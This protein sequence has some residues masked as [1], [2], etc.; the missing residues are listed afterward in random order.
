[1]RALTAVL[2]TGCN[3]DCAYCFQNAR[4]PRRSLSWPTLRAALD[5]LLASERD[6]VELAF[7]G[8]EPLLEFP[9]IEQAFAYVARRRRADQTVRYRLYTNGMLMGGR[10]AAFLATHQVKTQL[11]LDGVPSAQAQR[12]ANSF[13]VLD[14]LLDELREAH[15]SWFRHDLSVGMTVLPE[16]VKH[17]AAGVRYFLSKGLAEFGFSPIITDSSS[18]CTEQIAELDEQMEQVS[19]ICLEHYRE[20]G[21]VPC[22]LFWQ[23]RCTPASG[24]QGRPLCRV[25]RGEALSLD[26]D[27]HVSCCALFSRSFQAFPS[28]FL[29]DRVEALDLGDVR[30]NEWPRRLA[31]HPS[32][33]RAAEIFDHQERKHSSYRNCGA[34]EL[35]ETCEICPMAI[36]HI[37]GNTDPHR[38]PD[39]LCAF[40]RLAS[41][42]RDR[43]LATASSLRVQ[44]CTEANR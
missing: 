17:L 35:L 21:A 40:N 16:T 15:G 3:L 13:A 23:R 30:S 19:T 12:G 28:A 36:G 26:V 2:T 4:H 32:A 41:K 39:F 25:G 29:R 20:T 44:D 6:N 38:I 34:C 11:S 24:P 7:T 10:P 33:V 18:W 43:W 27:G 14:P 5:A 22:E 42:H 1:M 9:L 31:D 37:P 8:G